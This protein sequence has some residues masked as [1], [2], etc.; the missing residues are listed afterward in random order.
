MKIYS[1]YDP[2]TGLFTGRRISGSRSLL[3]RN[4]KEGLAIA[5]GTHDALSR[6]IDLATGEVVDYQPPRPSDDHEWV[7]RRWRLKPDAAQRQAS[8]MAAQR[9]ID[10][11]EAS[12]A[13][14]IRE[15]VLSGDTSRL[16]SIESDIA[17]LRQSVRG[18]K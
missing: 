5:E 12:Q 8:A 11:L 13:R 4:T 7:G 18:G 1:F 17:A 9:E 16:Q 14:A 10:R 6:R 15:A 3:A 2:A